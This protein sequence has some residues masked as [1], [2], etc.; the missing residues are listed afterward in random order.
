MYLTTVAK[1]VHPDVEIFEKLGFIATKLYNT[2]NWDRRDQWEKT[3]KIPNYFEQCRVLKDNPWARQL[4]SQTVQAIL[5]KLDEAYNAWYKLRKTDPTAKPPGFRKKTS[6]SSV[7]F[8]KSAIRVSNHTIRLSMQPSVHKERFYTFEYL[9]P[10]EITQDNL[11]KLE[12]VKRNGSWYSHITYEKKPKPLK[13][14]GG[15]KAIDL[16]IVH[17]AA[18]VNE[19]GTIKIYTGRDGLSIQRYFNKR[20]AH[21]Q[22]KAMKEQG[23]QWYT[24]LTELYRKKSRQI[25]H[26]LHTV[27]QALVRDCVRE[28]IKTVV[29]GDLSNIRKQGGGKAKKLGKVTNQKLHAWAF[30]Q[31]TDQLK[32]KL[33]L[34][35]IQVVQVCER[36]TS[37]TCSQCGYVESYKGQCRKHRGLYACKNCGVVLHADVNGALNILKKYLPEADVS[38]SSGAL[39]APSVVVWDYGSIR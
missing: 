36:N 15:I 33:A 38:W 18:T 2:A 13:Q 21:I 4:H 24:R 26:L 1:I 9:A 10:V 16:G 8:K 25:Q 32:Y 34:E 35:G 19:D 20:I 31:F 11:V 37:K 28:D 27:T 3:G 39:A 23:E 6:I 30:R 22:S 17:L 12:L 29:L 7:P 5:G 14:E